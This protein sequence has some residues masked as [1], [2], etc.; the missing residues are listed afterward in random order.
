MPATYVPPGWNE[1]DVA[2]WGYPEFNYTLNEDGQLQHYGDQ[3]SDYLTD[4]LADKGV[5]FINSSAAADQPFFLEL[6]TFAPHSPYTPGPAGRQRL[7]RPEGAAAA[8]LRPCCRP[9]RRSGWPH[10]RR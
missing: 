6:A 3:P 2:G 5:D 7:P 10:H 4:V 1:W 8:Q 9:T